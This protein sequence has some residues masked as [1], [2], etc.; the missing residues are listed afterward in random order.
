MNTRRKIN[1]DPLSV[2]PADVWTARID[3]RDCDRAPHIVKEENGIIGDFIEAMREV[4]RCA[5]TSQ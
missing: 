1:L 2:E 5:S 3:T 4:E